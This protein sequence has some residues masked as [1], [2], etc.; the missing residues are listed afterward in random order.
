M[1]TIVGALCLAASTLAASPLDPAGAKPPNTRHG[2]ALTPPKEKIR[3]AFVVTAGANVI[4]FGGPWEVFSSTHLPDRGTTYR[5]QNPFELF[6]V[7]DTSQP[8]VAGAPGNEMTLVPAYT[9]DTAPP[10]RLVVVGAQKGNAALLA[11][12]KKVSPGA[13]VTMSVCGGAFQLARAGLLDGQE[14]TTHHDRFEDFKRE[15]PRVALRRGVRFV[16]NA[17]VSTAGGLTSGIDLALRVVERYFGR[18]IAEATAVDLEYE[19]QGWKR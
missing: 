10:P 15:F 6:V 11:W 2:V 12:L 3:V 4:D 18:G 19:G 8:V 5:E 13:D 7:S 16:E 14:A 9:F 17:R 1:K